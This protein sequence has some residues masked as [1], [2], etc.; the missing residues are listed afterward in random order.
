MFMHLPFCRAAK[1]SLY[2][3]LIIRLGVVLSVNKTITLLH[4]NTH[5]CPCMILHWIHCA[6]N[7][8]SLKYTLA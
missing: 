7:Y 2:S 3:Q 8:L 6:V 4:N 5:I 1:N